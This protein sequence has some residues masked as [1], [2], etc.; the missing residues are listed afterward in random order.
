M[1][2]TLSLNLEMR[3]LS[4]RE[5]KQSLMLLSRYQPGVPKLPLLLPARYFA[6]VSWETPTCIKDLIACVAGAGCY[7]YCR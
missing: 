6:L 3:K 5:A 4:L 1:E 2:G 7:F